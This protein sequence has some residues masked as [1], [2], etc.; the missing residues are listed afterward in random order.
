MAEPS[1]PLDELDRRILRA[2]QKDGRQPVVA[3][4]EQVGLTPTPCLRRV[5]RLEEA[6]VITGYAAQLDANRLGLPVQAFLMVT[7][8]SHAEPIKQGFE[9]AL[10]RRPEVV[11]SYATSGGWDYLLHVMAPDMAAYSDFALRALLAMPG[12]KETRSSF[13]L[14]A[15]RAPAQVPV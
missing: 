1:T 2:L 8:E 14:H 7:L 15:L 12:V 11:A 3:L 4:A 10:A 5:K 6:G 13:V 9:A